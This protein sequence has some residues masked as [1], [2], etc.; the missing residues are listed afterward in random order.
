M[1]K[2]WAMMVETQSANCT[3]HTQKF[4]SARSLL[5]IVLAK[6]SVKDTTTC[7][8]TDPDEDLLLLLGLIIDAQR[9]VFLGSRF[10]HSTCTHVPPPPTKQLNGMSKCRAFIPAILLTETN[11]DTEDFMDRKE[12]MG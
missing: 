11:T 2:Q 4:C 5:L 12:A 8:C 9:A 3:C 7:T 6:C 1:S 10:L